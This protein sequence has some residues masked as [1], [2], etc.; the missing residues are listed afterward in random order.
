[1]A[2]TRNCI[3]RC[4][5]WHHR[6]SWRSKTRYYWFDIRPLWYRIGF[7]HG[8][9]CRELSASSCSCIRETRCNKHLWA[10]AFR[11]ATCTLDWVSYGQS[12]YNWQLWKKG[13]IRT[14][15]LYGETSASQTE[16][17]WSI[18]NHGGHSTI[19]WRQVAAWLWLIIDFSRAVSNRYPI[20]EKSAGEKCGQGRGRTCR[21]CHKR[22]EHERGPRT[23]GHARDRGRYDWRST[24]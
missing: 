2:T 21:W 8:G 5:W 9:W 22:Q 18:S 11:L 10:R 1:M 7:P 3:D 23:E 4:W 17:F 16:S 12:A 20:L 13:S 15:H 14:R 19:R 6:S 24:G